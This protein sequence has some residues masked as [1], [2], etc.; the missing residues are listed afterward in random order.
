M[1]HAEFMQAGGANLFFCSSVQ[2]LGLPRQHRVFI[3]KSHKLQY[4]V[5][6]VV[7]I[8]RNNYF[9]SKLE[10]LMTRA[11]CARQHG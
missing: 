6:L 10:K 4:D 2:L 11:K 5:W 3:I 7:G 9:R 8:F 1:W